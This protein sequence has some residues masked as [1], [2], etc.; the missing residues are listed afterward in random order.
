MSSEL[1]R[2]VIRLAAS[3]PE[4]RK[5]LLTILKEEADPTSHD[6]NLPETWYGLPP[7]GP[8]KTAGAAKVAAGPDRTGRNWKEKKIS[9][10]LHWIWQG[11]PGEP[12]FMVI[13]NTASFGK[14]YKMTVKLEDGTLLQTFGQK[15]EPGYWFKRA[16]ELYQRFQD[17]INIDFTDL[18]D[19]WNRIASAKV[20]A[21]KMTPFAEAYF[22]LWRDKAGMGDMDD[23]EDM[24]ASYKKGEVTDKE[25]FDGA[26]KSWKSKLPPLK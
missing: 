14:Y 5:D 11:R 9:G 7:Q 12:R 24:E 1:R 16:A 25:L 4:L 22:K 6:Q 10:I 19:K 20:A 2:R 13:E 26:P 18:P 8:G 15:L 17:T 23:I 3:T 21:K